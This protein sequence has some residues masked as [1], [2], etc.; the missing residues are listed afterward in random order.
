[1]ENLVTTVASPHGVDRGRC[2]TCTHFQTQSVDPYETQ[3]V[4]VC[5][6][7]GSLIP[8]DG[9][10]FCHE[11]SAQTTPRMTPDREAERQRLHAQHV[12]RDRWNACLR[13]TGWLLGWLL[14]TW[15]WLLLAFALLR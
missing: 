12:R 9:R 1:M 2:A 14:L 13:G 7:H 8:F 10:G 15:G 3:I 6:Y 5:G 11:W 4:A